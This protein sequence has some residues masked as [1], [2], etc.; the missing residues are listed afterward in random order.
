MRAK[1]LAILNNLKVSGKAITLIF[2]ILRYSS[3][4]NESVIKNIIYID[5]NIN[6][7]DNLIELFK[8]PFNNLSKTAQNIL[9]FLSKHIDEKTLNHVVY[10]FSKNPSEYADGWISILKDKTKTN[11][12][13]A[14]SKHSSLNKISMS[15]TLFFDFYALN[16]I[17]CNNLNEEK[18]MC[19]FVKEYTNKQIIDYLVDLLKTL[20]A[21]EASHVK[22]QFASG[23]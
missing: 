1:A 16:Y 7:I 17:D 2:Q 13:K 12:L 19:K 5:L 6:K 9:L 18:S 22:D 23:Y 3:Y 21:S 20:V 15:E 11:W 14:L 10:Y 4:D 8:I